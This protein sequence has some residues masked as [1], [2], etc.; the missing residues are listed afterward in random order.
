MICVKSAPLTL[1]AIEELTGLSREVLRKWELRSH[2]HQPARGER[3]ERRYSF[4]DAHR[5]QLVGQ[6][7]ACG[8]RP[9]RLVPLECQANIT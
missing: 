1:P 2:F 3:G 9:G 6:L 4:A 8:M 7:I 5:L